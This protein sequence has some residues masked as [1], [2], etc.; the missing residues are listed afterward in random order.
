MRGGVAKKKLETDPGDDRRASRHPICPSQPTAEPHAPRV[1]NG[2]TLLTGLAK[3]ATCGITLRTGKGGRDA[4][5]LTLDGASI[6]SD[7][8]PFC[9]FIA[10]R[11]HWSLE[12]APARP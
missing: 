10:E 5:L 4:Y 1:V 12:Q 9:G 7:I 3:R 11:A 8:A 2:P 6:D